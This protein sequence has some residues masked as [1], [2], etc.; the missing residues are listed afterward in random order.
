[1]AYALLPTGGIWLILRVLAELPAETAFAL[2]GLYLLL[3]VAQALLMN[4]K[5]SKANKSGK[6]RLLKS[7]LDDF[8]AKQAIKPGDISGVSDASFKKWPVGHD[9]LDTIPSRQSLE[10]WRPN[11]DRRISE[12]SIDDF[13]KT[14]NRR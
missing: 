5:T 13:V 6:R 7:S 11:P 1:V 9:V 14:S 12:V 3:R 2:T 4:V 8:L 10:S